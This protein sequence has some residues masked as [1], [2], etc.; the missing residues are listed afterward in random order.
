[1]AVTRPPV[2]APV[3]FAKGAAGTTPPVVAE[4]VQAVAEGEGIPSGGT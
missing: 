4:A 1:L 2:P 3:Y